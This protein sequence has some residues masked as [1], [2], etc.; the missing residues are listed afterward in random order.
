MTVVVVGAA[1][2]KA[3]SKPES[4]RTGTSL[5]LY[6]CPSVPFFWTI[7]IINGSAVIAIDLVSSVCATVVGFSLF[8]RHF[9]SPTRDPPIV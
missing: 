2:F 8:G 9:L 5:N 4:R 1:L 3:E 7:V 6:S